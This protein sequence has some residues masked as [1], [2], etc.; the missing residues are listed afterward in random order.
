MNKDHGASLPEFAPRFD[1]PLLRP[2]WESLREGRL[3]LP[4]CSTCGAWQWY[5]FE[6]VKCHPGA[7]HEW[8]PVPSVGQVFTFTIVHRSFLANASKDASPYISAL[9]ELDG[10]E[11]ARIPALLV[12]FGDLQPEIGMRVQLVPI[13][14]DGYT[15][16]AFEPC[17]I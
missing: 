12:N 8:K 9:I 1:T 10:I 2:Y 5:P 13:L 16:P 11:G 14:R 4:A 7:S 3:S 6:F 17:G 15:A